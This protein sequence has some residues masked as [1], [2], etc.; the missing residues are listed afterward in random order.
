VA[1]V[2]NL[3]RAL[4]LSAAL[5]AGPLAAQEGD[6]VARG[7]YLVRAGGC[8]ACHSDLESDGPPFAGGG[9]IETPFG[10]FHAPNITPD[11]IHGIGGW[12]EGDLAA[13][14]TQG[15][16]PDGGHYYPVFPY[17]TYTRI[18]DPDIADLWAYLQS[19]PSVARPRRAHVLKFPFSIRSINLAWKVMFFEPQRFAPDPERTA[20]WNRGAYLVEALGHC[21]ECHTPRNP[22]GGL[23]RDMAQA[24]TRFGPDGKSVPNITPDSETGIGDWSLGD[25]A[26]LLKT[27]FTP[28]GDDVQ[29]R[30]SEVVE[31][32]TS[33]LTGE[34]R[35]AIAVYLK[36]LSP[37]Y[38]PVRPNDDDDSDTGGD[39]W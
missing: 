32:G 26:W 3:A 21:G 15:T 4:A 1:R 16:A 31:H 36:S 35:T 28:E 17:T 33:H 24:G 30:M 12:S 39:D 8:L 5:T 19:L 29:G 22:L 7:G 18:T 11:P 34:D 23:S 37:I 20:Q 6:P 38:N 9:P 13:A 2:R 25:I 10:I 27:G 14:L